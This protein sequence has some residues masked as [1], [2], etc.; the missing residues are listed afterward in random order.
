[1]VALM[2]LMMENYLAVLMVALTAVLTV[3]TRVA[4]EAAVKVVKLAES[5]DYTMVWIKALM[6][7]AL[8]VFVKDVLKAEVM[9]DIAVA[10]MVAFAAVSMGILPA[11]KRDV[12][13]VVRKVEYM[14]VQMVPTKVDKRVRQR[15]SK[16]VRQWDL[17][18]ENKMALK[19]DIHLVCPLEITLVRKKDKRMALTKGVA[20]AGRVVEKLG[21]VKV[22]LTVV[23]TVV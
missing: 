15:D 22:A 5:L 12:S 19:K 18:W 9:V 11:E 3:D 20:S 6:K 2:A 14:V 1:M 7:A 21:Y 13:W 16:L 4:N 17:W 8:R 23:S 10:L